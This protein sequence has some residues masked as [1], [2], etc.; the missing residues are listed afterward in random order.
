MA[1]DKVQLKREEV[2]GNDVVMQDINPKTKTNSI[3]DS[4]K[5]IPLD[6]TLAMIKNMINNKL[7]R[8]VN[9]V[10]GRTGIVII[11][12]NDVGLGN[13]DNVSF[14][15]I[16]RW[17]IDY[18]G[19]IFGTKRLI[20]REYLSDISAILGTNDRTYADRPFYTQKGDIANNRDYLAYIGYIY[21]DDATS[22][23][24][25]E[26][27]SIKVV[28]FTDESLVYNVDAGNPSDPNDRRNL[29]HG[30]LGVNI[31]SG[32]DALKIRR[33]IGGF[34]RD[35]FDA[36]TLN[37]TGLYIDK[38]KLVPNVYFFDG[39][40]G[41][42][43][44]ENLNKYC[45][46]GLVYWSD[47]TSDTTVE[48]L[49]I[50]QI[51]INGVDIFRSTAHGGIR[52]LPNALHTP[53][54]N[55]K[56]GDIILT[57]FSYDQYIDT[58]NIDVENPL[59]P[60]MFDS[61]TCRQPAYGIVTQSADVEL[62]RPCIV[63]FKPSKP[64]VGHG[65]KLLTT[66]DGYATP[67]DTIVGLDLFETSPKMS[68]G[69][70][71]YAYQSNVSGINALDKTSLSD[72]HTR[73]KTEKH[74]Y[75]VYPT[76]KS[77]N[78][79][80]PDNVVDIN[81]TFIMPNFSLCVIPG[82]ELTQHPTERPIENWNGTSPMG[83]DIYSLR[84][85]TWDMLGINLEKTI[86]GDEG[87]HSTWGN[88]KWCRNISGLRVNTD[89]DELHE[90]WFGF[91]TDTPTYLYSKHSGGL[92]VNVGDFLGIGTAEEL[93]STD[94]AEIEDYYD[95]G[96]VNVRIDKMKGLY[97]SGSNT[98]GVHI[99][100][101]QTY[102]SSTSPNKPNW[103][104]GGLIFVN[105]GD[106]SPN[107]GLLAVNTGNGSSGLDV[108]NNYYTG[109]RYFN[110]GRYISSVT[111]QNALAVKPFKFASSVYD[112]SLD[113]SGIEVHR[114][115]SE[116]D[117]TQR[118][119]ITNIYSVR[120]WVSYDALHDEMT[121]HPERFST[122][123]VYVAAGKRYIFAQPNSQPQTIPYFAYYSSADDYET[124]IDILETGVLP[125]G[126]VPDLSILTRQC[127]VLVAEDP[128]NLNQYIVKATQTKLT[129]SSSLRFPDLDRNGL[130]TNV[131]ASSILTAVAKY[132]VAIPVY[133][134]TVGGVVK[135]YTDDA[136]TTELEPVIGQSY[137]DLSPSQ[138]IVDPEDSSHEYHKLYEGVT[139]PGSTVVYLKPFEFIT[140]IT[141]TN[142]DY[143]FADVWRNGEITTPDASAVLKYYA[144]SSSGKYPGVTP[145]QAWKM[146]LRNDLG[147]VISDEVS[148]VCEVLN[149]IWQKGVRVR[150]N[151]LKG[152]TTNPEYI[153][154]SSD[155]I[156]DMIDNDVTNA[157]AV[158]IA[159][160]SSGIS[161]FD[162]TKCGGL[163]FGSS[164]YLGI[165]VNN[166]NDF[167]A[168][169]PLKNNEKCAD[170]MSE[171]S[172]GLKIYP[173]NVLGVQLTKDG[174]M[175]NGELRIGD[176][177]CLHLSPELSIRN[178]PL[179]FN[180]KRS[181]GTSTS[182]SYSGNEPITI[183]LGPGLCFDT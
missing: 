150:Y 110:Y 90:S 131:E 97:N 73:P 146:F 3:Q 136:L 23:L 20:L 87:D 16:K 11:D 93:A 149:C 152:L 10:N 100:E 8:V 107:H 178:Q 79:L 118:I 59:Y 63:D 52:P 12:A 14:G 2:V 154:A 157:L 128:D 41:D 160:P 89:T 67:A 69:T 147:I 47:D 15:D 76:G 28:G 77:S 165:R 39:I 134:T 75:T 48:T 30:G 72:R 138:A 94:H 175:D 25:E 172:H 53:L 4:T 92:S 164:G 70:T 159:D 55:L 182:I 26:H 143:L 169:T 58:S 113:T 36:E 49:P 179:T 46:N 24:K 122:D 85:G 37:D 132:A 109:A 45:R 108:M 99:A 13:V 123:Y 163:R 135:Y 17:V 96:K 140:S 115:V 120:S 84:S 103:L 60:G 129:S 114:E 124:L 130:V 44:S 121:E 125:E 177:G 64:N 166:N 158:K 116:Y 98:L 101:G 111:V 42:V 95:E 43:E 86:F 167:S 102:E 68:D 145:E 139:D 127:H 9:S 35:G 88:V 81:S 51:T 183:N 153:G 173:G 83:D 137:C 126:D 105:G 91:G 156:T 32:E 6:Q 117:L 119:S 33:A 54:T 161:V 5:G 62:N 18:I 74:I 19:D 141:P 168:I 1:Q 180:G 22:T 151:E 148:E 61:L 78:L 80:A 82:F 27:F 181:D 174:E 31:W 29:G 38:E 162:P 133:S 40:Y 65:L 50:I 71:I 155:T 171:G 144:N 104:S 106:A 170:D 176:D 112:R 57:N 56:V 7:S 142:D 34:S 66:D 21:W